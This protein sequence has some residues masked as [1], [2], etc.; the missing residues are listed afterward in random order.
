MKQRGEVAPEAATCDHLDKRPWIQFLQRNYHV[1][2]ANMTL[3]GWNLAMQSL[4]RSHAKNCL[5]D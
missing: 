1:N 3:L 4:P 5:R 2:L